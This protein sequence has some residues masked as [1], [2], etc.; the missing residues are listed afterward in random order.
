M[1]MTNELAA[2]F[3]DKVVSA[4][5]TFRAGRNGASLSLIHI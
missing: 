3:A 4:Q 5:A 2:G 1:T